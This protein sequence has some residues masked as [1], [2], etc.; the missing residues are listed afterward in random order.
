MK[1]VLNEK[2]HCKR[3]LQQDFEKLFNVEERII[4]VNVSAE[5][6]TLGPTMG[7]IDSTTTTGA[8]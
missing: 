7:M 5:Y 4:I 6:Q 3:I 8:C 1:G 2:Y